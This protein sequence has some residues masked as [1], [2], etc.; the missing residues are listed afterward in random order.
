MS[1]GKPPFCSAGK[2]LSNVNPSSRAASTC[3]VARR[4]EGER[5]VEGSCGKELCGN[6]QAGRREGCGESVRRTPPVVRVGGEAAHG[7]GAEDLLEGGAADDL[8]TAV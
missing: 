3:H 8:K 2:N 1:F 4:G 6:R 7:G 5:A